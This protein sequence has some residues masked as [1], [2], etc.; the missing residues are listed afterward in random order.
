MQPKR[1]HA[2]WPSATA[3]AALLLAL[4]GCASNSQNV[5]QFAVP[6]ADYAADP[7]N[8]AKVVDGGE[9]VYQLQAGDQ[10]EVKFYYHPE[11]NELL[12]IGPD[13]R[14]SLQLIGELNVSG[15]SPQQ[16]SEQLATRYAGTLRNP[17]ATVMLRKYAASRIYV[18]GEV[19]QA[20]AHII[21][22]NRLTALQAITL[23]GGFRKGAERGN[24]IVLRNSGSGKPTFIKLDLQGHLEQTAQADLLLRPY[25]IVYVP[26]RRIAEV[27]DFF[28]EYFNKIVPLYR[29]LGFQFTYNLR[30]TVQVQPAPQ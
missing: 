14:I 10:V 29:N 16:L 3:A 9:L 21:E 30:N 5:G 8:Q 12:T 19:M 4:A 23:S 27:A 7:A 6:A 13:A 28:E 2:R 17:Q 20:T 22:G 24:V 11:L 15:M 18:A 25:D 1:L 26:Q